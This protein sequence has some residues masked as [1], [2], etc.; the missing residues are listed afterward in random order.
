MFPQV[1]RLGALHAEKL[2]PCGVSVHQLWCVLNRLHYSDRDGFL[3]H[4]Q[5]VAV[6]RHKQIPST[7]FC[8]PRSYDTLLFLSHHIKKFPDQDYGTRKAK[9]KSYLRCQNLQYSS[10]KCNEILLHRAVPIIVSNFFLTR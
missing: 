10:V 1:L 9:T 3:K 2:Q 5:L 6:S 8:S 4:C 7:Q